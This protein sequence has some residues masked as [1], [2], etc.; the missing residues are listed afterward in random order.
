MSGKRV[1]EILFDQFG[2]KEFLTRDIP[3]DVMDQLTERMEIHDAGPGRKI[4]VGQHISELEGFQYTPESGL[5]VEMT[6]TRPENRRL[7]RR[8]RFVDATPPPP[9]HR[10]KVTAVEDPETTYSYDVVLVE[11]EEGWAVFCPALRGCVSQGDS[12]AEALENIQEAMIGWLKGEAR[13]VEVEILNLL[14][15][16]NEAGCPAKRA[17]VSVA[18]MKANATVH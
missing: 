14:D 13:D 11:S 4:K 10:H 9:K 17:T 15:E 16:Y 5:K 18:R 2:Y 12:E 1:G 3:P 6:V 7:P 8:F